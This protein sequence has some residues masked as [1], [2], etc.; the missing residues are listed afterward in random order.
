MKKCS[1][2]TDCFVQHV[3]P[4]RKCYLI[5]GRIHCKKKSKE[6][7]LGRTKQTLSKGLAI[8]FP[9]T[10][11]QISKMTRNVSKTDMSHNQETS[12]HISKGSE[13][14]SLKNYGI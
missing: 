6:Q 12:E 4:T 1:K 5:P 13:N 11:N 2:I 9:K 7:T 8:E 3:N 10:I 14:S